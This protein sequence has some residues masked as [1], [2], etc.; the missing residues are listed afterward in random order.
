MAIQLGDL[1]PELIIKCAEYTDPQSLWNWARTCKGYMILFRGV[2]KEIRQCALVSYRPYLY[3]WQPLLEAV[4]NG[5]YKQVEKALVR[6]H[7]DPN[8][9]D[10]SGRPLLHTAVPCKQLEIARLLL[11]H[12]ASPDDPYFYGAVD[13]WCRRPTVEDASMLELLMDA[14]ARVSGLSNPHSLLRSLI[15]IPFEYAFLNRAVRY[16]L[17]PDPLKSGVLGVHFNVDM[18]IK[19]GTVNFMRVFLTLEPNLLQYRWKKRDNPNEEDDPITRA[20]SYDRW[21]IAH[22]L[23]EFAPR[24][25]KNESS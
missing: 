23:R 15:T 14:G 22:C 13:C 10:Q 9:Y 19:Q 21:D 8:S 17:V 5:E 20:I 18:A 1:P 3:T 25:A 16:F 6:F 11:Y 4:R 2:L 24:N 12:G 7:I